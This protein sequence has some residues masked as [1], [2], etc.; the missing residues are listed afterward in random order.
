MRLGELVGKMIAMRVSDDFGDRVVSGVVIDGTVTID[1]GGRQLLVP[2]K[3]IRE[4]R[5]IE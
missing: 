2:F 4:V 3:R 1:M 5:I